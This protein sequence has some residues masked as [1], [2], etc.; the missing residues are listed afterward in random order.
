MNKPMEGVFQEDSKVFTKEKLEN[1]NSAKSKG[2]WRGA[3]AG[4]IGG[5]VTAGGLHFLQK[6][7]RQRSI[8]RSFR[9]K[10][11]LVVMSVSACFWITCE[12]TINAEARRSRSERNARR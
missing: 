7:L 6:Y 5:L 8:F 9:T 10:T 4:V 11:M 1:F 2:L 12:H 3:R